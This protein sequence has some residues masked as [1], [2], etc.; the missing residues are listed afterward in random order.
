MTAHRS[1]SLVLGLTL[2]ISVVLAG[3][4]SLTLR[5]IDQQDIPVASSARGALRF[6]AATYP[7]LPGNCEGKCVARAVKIANLLALSKQGK[8]PLVDLAQDLGSGYYLLNSVLLKGNFADRTAEF[9]LALERLLFSNRVKAMAIILGTRFEGSG[10]LEKA[11]GLQDHAHD[12]ETKAVLQREAFIFRAMQGQDGHVAALAAPEQASGPSF[13]AAY[14]L[15]AS[16]W[17]LCAIRDDRGAEYIKRATPY[18]FSNRRALIHAIA[19]N[20]D[21]TLIAAAEM[22]GACQGHIDELRARLID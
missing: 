18:L 15:M 16:G 14:Q 6:I 19:R 10:I 11:L 2:G 3:A 12:E 4:I 7:L 22:N 1:R 20:L 8:K 21:V 17:A 5:W 9:E 13:P